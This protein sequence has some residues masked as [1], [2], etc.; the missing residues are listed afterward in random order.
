MGERFEVYRYT[1]ERPGE[2]DETRYTFA[3]HKG[4]GYAGNDEASEAHPMGNQ[5]AD[6]GQTSLAGHVEAPDGSK[7]VS[8]EP[9]TL[10]IPGRGRVDLDA[11]IGTTEGNADELGHL[12]RWRPRG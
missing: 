2:A 3:P 10:E 8:M 7:I 9:P 6:S 4:V 1:I 11:V 12:V 5:E